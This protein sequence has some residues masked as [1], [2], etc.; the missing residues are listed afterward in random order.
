MREG[1]IDC[2]VD[3]PDS[4]PWNYKNNVKKYYR[5]SDDEQV[6]YKPVISSITENSV[7]AITKQH[8]IIYITDYF[9]WFTNPTA[10]C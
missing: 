8:V 4:S 9:S 2:S 5:F 6:F 1:F 3:L 7:I 10:T